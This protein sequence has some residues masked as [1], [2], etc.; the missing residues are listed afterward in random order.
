MKNKIG[1]CVLLCA[2][3]C[4]QEF[5]E[6][7]KPDAAREA[8]DQ[9]AMAQVGD[10]WN[11]QGEAAALKFL[12]EEAKAGNHYAQLRLA[13]WFSQGKQ[14]DSAE[15]RRWL[16]AAAAQ[17]DAQAQFQLAWLE[18]GEAGLRWL[19]RAA[20][21]GYAPAQAQ[22]AQRQAQD[23]DADAPN[24]Q[25]WVAQAA[26]Q[27]DANA[28]FELGRRLW[29]QGNRAAALRWLELAAEQGHVAAQFELGLA[30]HELGDAVRATAWW[31][32]AAE[33]GHAQAKRMLRR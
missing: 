28:Q 24:A 1:L 10:L 13:Q 19:Q 21:Q 17:G 23:A 12:Q 27:E 7:A 29:A 25:D 30:H 22:L 4:A 2:L 8:R 11:T 32:R 9:A 18:D 6:V 33:G 31:Q 16:K 26:A 5:A 20:A 14:Q 15:M 3:G